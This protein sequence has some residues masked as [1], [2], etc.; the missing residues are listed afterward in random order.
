M[1]CWIAAHIYSDFNVEFIRYAS[2][3]DRR[4]RT[5]YKLRLSLARREGI[6]VSTVLLPN[7]TEWNIIFLLDK[8]CDL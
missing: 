4:I 1:L 2:K 8:R 3:L 7:Y 5:V 6:T